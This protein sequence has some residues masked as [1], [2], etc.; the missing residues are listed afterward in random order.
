MPQ[1]FAISDTS[2]SSDIGERSKN[3][4]FEIYLLN[5]IILSVYVYM[6]VTKKLSKELK[7]N[8]RA[9]KTA[10]ESEAFVTTETTGG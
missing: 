7:G 9:A 10:I 3:Q 8:R 5:R 2:Y 4:I 1:N 6:Y